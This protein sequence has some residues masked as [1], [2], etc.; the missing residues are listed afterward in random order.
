MQRKRVK[1][2]P[3]EDDLGRLVGIV[4]RS[5]LLKVHLRTDAEIRRDVVDEVLHQV[6]AVETGKVR[7]TTTDGVVT[8]S[9][10]LHF[11]SAADK[12]ARLTAHVPGVV[13]LIDEITY[14]IDDRLAVGSDS[15]APIGVA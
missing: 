6:L 14:D 13:D 2:L 5:D 12:A 4:T 8:L 15:G 10:H 7:V 9:G 11:R 1:R 3:V